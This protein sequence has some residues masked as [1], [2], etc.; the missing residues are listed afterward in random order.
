[1]I[2]S[3]TNYLVAKVPSSFFEVS[4]SEVK[5]VLRVASLHLT[6]VNFVFALPCFV[7]ALAFFGWHFN[8]IFD[9]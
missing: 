1:M 6:W 5:L 7:P 9:Q 3:I 4:C 8:K 2:R